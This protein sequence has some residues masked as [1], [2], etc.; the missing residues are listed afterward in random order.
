MLLVA[1]SE[2]GSLWQSKEIYERVGDPKQLVIVEDA[3]EIAF[4]DIPK[5]VDKERLSPFFATN[6]SS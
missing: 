5:N 1:S 4:Y 3:A 2:A 6:L